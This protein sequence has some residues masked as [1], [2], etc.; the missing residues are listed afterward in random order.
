MF[1]NGHKKREL[2]S[3]RAGFFNFILAKIAHVNH[4]AC[5][6]AH[7]CHRKLRFVFGN[8]TDETCAYTRIHVLYQRYKSIVRGAVNNSNRSPSKR[9]CSRLRISTFMTR[10]L[11][12]G[13]V[14]NVIY[15]RPYVN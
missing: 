1:R 5:Y 8:T 6:V 11:R 13:I 14:L 7:V 9:V 15:V 3:S 10:W 12:N 4:T 2:F